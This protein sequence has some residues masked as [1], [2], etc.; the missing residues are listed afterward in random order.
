[1]RRI[2]VSRRRPILRVRAHDVLLRHGP[3][4]GEE[5]LGGLV[6]GHEGDA[7]LADGA[8]VVHV[9]EPAAQAGQ[10]GEA[11]AGEAEREAGE[12]GRRVSYLH[13]TAVTGCHS[14]GHAGVV[15]HRMRQHAVVAEGAV[16]DG[17]QVGEALQGHR[18]AR[19]LQLRHGGIVGLLRR[20]LFA[21]VL[22]LCGLLLLWLSRG[23]CVSSCLGR[24]R[25]RRR[26]DS[27][28]LSV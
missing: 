5:D 1:M 17:G 18:V 4:G 23:N 26:P 14:Q 10:A 13:S 21:L 25:G 7:L 9:L 8:V 16:D 24:E 15:L 3:G 19:L 27:S 20:L 2:A 28:F 12:A 22:V 6:V 11:E